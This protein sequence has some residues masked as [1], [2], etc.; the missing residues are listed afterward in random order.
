MFI[1]VT[2]VGLKLKKGKFATCFPLCLTLFCLAF[3]VFSFTLGQAEASSSKL[4]PTSRF[5]L[6]TYDTFIY[7][8]ET[9]Y[10][11]QALVYGDKVVFSNVQM[12]SGDTV[13]SLTISDLQNANMTINKLMEAKEIKVTFDAAS[14]T[15]SGV[16][17][18]LPSKPTVVK[19]E[20]VERTEGV[21]W[22][23]SDSYSRITLMPV[24]SSTVSVS[25][26]WTTTSTGGSTGPGGPTPPITPP[27]TP[28][29]VAPITPAPAFPPTLRNV[30]LL[31]AVAV[32]V[33]LLVSSA[34]SEI[35]LTK[36][37]RKWGGQRKKK[38][39]KQPEWEKRDTWD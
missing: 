18:S 11:T 34:T 39:K 8:D 4:E 25:M 33:V 30:I 13:T 23:W 31:V 10:C 29:Y 17:L 5:K 36:S 22:T 1:V 6:D 24:H 7:Y 37:R 2:C 15:T 9:I 26:F 21:G 38:R 32:A 12:G 28:P 20:G 27:I 19:V 14:G 3:L 35:D 16:K